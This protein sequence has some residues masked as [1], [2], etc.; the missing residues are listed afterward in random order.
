MK[1]L[2]AQWEEQECLIVAMPHINTD[3]REYLEDI[4]KSYVRFINAVAKFQPCLVLSNEP[5]S[6]KKLFSDISNLS[7]AKI[8]NDDTWVRDFGMI[9][10]FDEDR[11]ISY[12]FKF[13]AWGGKFGFLNDDKVS[14]ILYENKIL[15]GKLIE[16]NFIL[17]GGSIDTNGDGVMLST[18]KCLY[19][20][21]R[22][23]SLNKEQICAELKEFFGLKKLIILENGFI[24]GDDTDSHIDTLA[25]FI[26]KNTIAY[27]KCEDEKDLHFEEL[28]KMENELKQ[29]NFNLLPLP[30]PEPVYHENTRLP[31][32]YANFVFVNGALI[33][34]TYNQKKDE[35]VLKLLQ[36]A[37]PNLKVVGVDARV[38]IRQNGS[39]HCA[40]MNRY[41]GQ[42]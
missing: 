31:A 40:S 28:T 34:P 27:V 35:I 33:V 20:Q 32:T 3:W 5:E 42:R 39:L 25:R 2:P 17:E 26:N 13:N 6:S 7:F 23:S 18:A 15:K 36:N 19:T 11:L 37:L 10:C 12:D 41:K 22:N 8:T 30:L 4:T 16:Q 1:R 29:T 38:F 14:K 24:K 9:D 21:T